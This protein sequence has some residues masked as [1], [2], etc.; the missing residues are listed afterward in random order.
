MLDALELTDRAAELHAYLGVV[1]GG[2]DAPRGQARR[3][4]A[5]QDRGQVAH[6]GAADAAQDALG[7]D[8]H[9]GQLHLGDRPGQI[10]RGQLGDGGGGG[11]DQHPLLAVGRGHGQDERVGQG[12]AQHGLRRAGDDQ[13]AVLAA[14]AAQRAAQRDGAGQRAVGERLQVLGTL[15]GVDH[16]TGQHGRHVRARRHPLGQRLD[17]HGRL[18]QPVAGAAVLLGHVQAEQPLL[19]QA[20][21]ERGASA[22]PGAQQ[23]RGDVP[24]GPAAHRLAERL[25]LLAQPDSHCSSSSQVRE[26][27]QN[28]ILEDASGVSA[29]HSGRTCWTSV[30][31]SRQYF[32]FES[33]IEASSMAGLVLPTSITVT[34]ACASCFLPLKV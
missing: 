16:G 5:E 25:V 34:T 7:G 20:R 1:G 23:L 26:S 33:G 27:T 4:G 29:C 8:D 9:V 12:A 32:L 3:L 24:L 19:G 30:F 6:V 22:G 10:E 11:V 17:R 2:G 15:G 13:G 18:Q 28:H 21:P 31:R 14:G